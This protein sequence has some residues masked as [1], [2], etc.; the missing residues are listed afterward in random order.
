MKPVLDALKRGDEEQALELLVEAWR[1]TRA[2]EVADV[3]TLLGARL[4]AAL[5]R[6]EGKLADFQPL[7]LAVAARRRA[8]DVPRLL[9]SI[10]HTTQ[11]NGVAITNALLERGQA[12][13]SWPADPR[14]SLAIA[15][16][17]RKGPF[18]ATGKAQQPFWTGLFDLVLAHDDARAIEPF[19]ALN[20][21]KIWKG[22]ND[23]KAR[24]AFLQPAVG[25]VVAG[26]HERPAAKANVRAVRTAIEKLGPVDAAKLVTPV[27]AAAP[28]KA[29]PVPM[30]MG[31]A[32]RALAAAETALGT[33]DERALEAL[34][35]AWRATRAPRIAELIATLSKR[36]DAR[37]TPITGASRRAIH[38]AWLAVAKQRRA[39]DI[40]RLLASITHTFH[41]ATD[42]LA[43]LEALA[44]WPPDPRAA[45]GAVAN[46]AV[47]PFYTS[48]TKPFWSALIE[49]AVRHGDRGTADALEGVA[50]KLGTILRAQY[51]DLTAIRTWFKNQLGAAVAKLRAIPEPPFDDATASRI[52]TRIG[53]L[54]A[55]TDRL[56]AAVYAAPA[57]DAPR[58]VLGDHLQELGDP[59]GELIA[60]SL[61]GADRKREREL[62]ELHANRWAGALARIAHH[63]EF[64]RGFI[65]EVHLMSDVPPE[66]IAE[67]IGDPIWTTVRRLELARPATKAER[68]RI[69]KM[70]P[71]GIDVHWT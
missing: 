35:E 32:A 56:F 22:W 7:W 25:R 41:R 31:D 63:F 14:I 28:K 67:T 68:T 19:A 65:H 11:Q 24:I 69:E 46:L 43:R 21:T 49:F 52:A 62:L 58:H 18:N 44:D 23:V 37:Q 54:V 66:A 51:T 59:R 70:L 13:A 20:F 53:D 2:A 4:D 33:S 8:V 40:P 27:V 71:R 10:L 39:A 48:S 29:K 17:L 16:H 3:A 1:S 64:E 45:A 30:P 12:L 34:L 60:L 61:S 57:D 9:E 50:S 6:L 5:P 36:I 26:L 15:A 47:L 38:D 42:A 55:T